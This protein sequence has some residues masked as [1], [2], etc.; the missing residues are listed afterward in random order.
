MICLNLMMYGASS[1]VYKISLGE[2][3]RD[4]V[5]NICESVMLEY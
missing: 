1:Y 3:I 5:N 2:D 4:D